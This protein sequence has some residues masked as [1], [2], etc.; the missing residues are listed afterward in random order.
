MPVFHSG[1][2]S[3]LVTQSTSQRTN[4]PMSWP[5]E[6]ASLT[7]NHAVN[8]TVKYPEKQ[9][10]QPHCQSIPTNKRVRH[11]PANIQT[12]QPPYQAKCPAKMSPNE[13]TTHSPS[14]PSS[15]LIHKLRIPETSQFFWHVK[16]MLHFHLMRCVEVKNR[17]SQR[18]EISHLTLLCPLS[19]TH[20]FVLSPFLNQFVLCL[21]HS[22]S[23]VCVS[24][25]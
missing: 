8:H 2:D 23:S 17:Q 20:Y 24:T 22:L 5:E 1:K 16:N 18:H 21:S 6:P 7:T 3:L 19:N 14:W 15:Q 13:T 4:Q 25:F 10:K 11:L 9:K 12:S